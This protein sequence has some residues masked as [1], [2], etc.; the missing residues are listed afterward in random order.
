VGLTGHLE[1]GD[2]VRVGAQSGVHKSIPAGKTVFGSP[3]RDNM[4]TKRIEAALTRLP[5]LLKRVRKIEQK[6]SE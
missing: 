2:G 3:A 5:E 4:I 6:L 1:I